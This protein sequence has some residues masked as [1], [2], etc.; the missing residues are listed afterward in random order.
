MQLCSM[1]HKIVCKTNFENQ[2]LSSFSTIKKSINGEE[3]DGR[4]ISFC[5]Y[6]LNSHETLF[7]ITVNSFT[8]LP[9][10]IFSHLLVC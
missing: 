5:F 10:L 3:G 6:E 1:F 2:R 4:V 9:L 8:F 7:T